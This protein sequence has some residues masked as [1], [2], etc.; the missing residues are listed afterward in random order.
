[1]PEEFRACLRRSDSWVSF[2]HSTNGLLLDAVLTDRGREFLS[3]NDGSFSI[4][5][6]ALGDDE[7]D[8]GIISQF[9]RTVGK[10]KIEKN[11]PIFEALT[12]QNFALKHPLICISNPNLI[13]LPTLSLTGEGV[14]TTSTIV[15]MGRN[16][17]TKRSLTVTQ[18][19]Q[20]ESTI[21][22]ELR[23]QAF[24]VQI[25]NQFLEIVGNSP[26]SI[27]GYNSATYLIPRSGQ[28]AA[29]E[30]S[31]LTF[32]LQVKTLTAAQFT[33][34]GS[35]LDKS[36]ISTFAR[37]TGLQSGAVKEFEIQISNA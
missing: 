32:D 5:K 9:G 26:D 30:G 11:T 1:M 17:N 23:D 4:V 33:V 35:T 20:N 34:F 18:T 3:R 25:D 36:V 24:R 16:T 31:K 12:N 6:F 21:D 13:R 28:R 10:E 29:A 37:V 27:D 7:I 19:I 2:D 15:T 8:Y 22:V 14:D